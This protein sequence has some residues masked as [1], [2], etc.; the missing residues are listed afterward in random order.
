M[1]FYS[2]HLLVPEG[3]GLGPAI[4]DPLNKRAALKK[5]WPK[6]LGS[7]DLAPEVW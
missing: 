3:P 5:A 7:G 2:R 4:L 1:L 6:L